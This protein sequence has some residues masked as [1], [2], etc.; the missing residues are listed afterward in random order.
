[1]S[2][3]KPLRIKAEVFWAKDAYILNKRFDEDNNKYQ[4]TLGNLSEAASEA[5]KGLGIKIKD[6]E[7]PGKHI[8]GKSIYPFKFFNEDGEEIPAEKVGNGSEVIALVSAYM[9]KLSKMHGA[10]PSVKKLIVT[11]LLEYNPERAL[12]EEDTIL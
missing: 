7:I 4:V 1:M 8:V 11:K 5:L 10:A 3:L 12:E 9:H 6:K 2:D